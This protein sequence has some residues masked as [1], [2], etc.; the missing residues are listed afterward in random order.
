MLLERAGEA[1]LRLGRDARATALLDRA[2][3]QPDAS[4]RAWNLRGIAA[5]RRGA[6]DEADAAYA[7]AEALSPRQAVVANNRGWSLMLRGRWAE[8]ADALEAALAL[9]PAVANGAAN[10]ELARAALAADLPTRRAGE[11]DRDFAG[12]L[13]D[14]GVVADA[15]GERARAIAAF[16]NAIAVRSQ[17]FA[18]AAANL[19]A[20]EQSP[21]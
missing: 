9:D 10:L 18:L 7:K 11:S 8:A 12:R 20:V 15:R 17:W 16:S 19:A 2:T 13:N 4:W 21:R 14:A 5:D 1:A 6:F 3:T